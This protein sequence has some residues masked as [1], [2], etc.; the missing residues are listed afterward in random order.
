MRT[1]FATVFIL[2]FLSK[3]LLAQPIPLRK[4]SRQVTDLT[5]HVYFLVDTS[6]QLSLQ[7]LHQSRFQKQF[8]PNKSGRVTYA[9][10]GVVWLKFVLQADAGTYL[11]EL[12][13]SQLA[14]G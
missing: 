5:P 11:L 2:I 7:A 6:R 4:A 9:K 12:K 8:R 1:N 3:S 10:N 14:K 13:E